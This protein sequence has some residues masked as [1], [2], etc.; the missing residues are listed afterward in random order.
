MVLNST[1]FDKAMAESVKGLERE[2]RWQ[3][4]GFYMECYIFFSEEN[5]GLLKVLVRGADRK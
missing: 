2:M 4:G 3:C 1:S 5:L